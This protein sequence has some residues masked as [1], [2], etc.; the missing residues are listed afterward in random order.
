MYKAW[1]A[2]NPEK[3]KAAS[4]TWRA[5]N[6]CYSERNKEKCK[7]WRMA[8]PEKV[9]AFA[10]EWRAANLDKKNAAGAQRRSAKLQATPS[11]ANQFFIEEIYDLAQLRTKAT[12]FKWVVDHTV[13]L[14]SKKVCGLHWEGN[15]RVISE[16]ENSS[17]GNRFWPGMS[18]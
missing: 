14:K 12:G 10:K 4:K 2:A 16:K 17:K 5:A 11:W 7:V 8:N 13:Q 9:K 18:N 3:A 6:P 1:R 15:L